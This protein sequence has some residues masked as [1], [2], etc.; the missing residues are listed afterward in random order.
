MKRVATPWAT[1]ALL[2]AI[3]AAAFAATLAPDSVAGWGFLR[4][5]PWSLTLLSHTLVHLNLVHLLGNLVV[6]AAVGPYVE[7]TLGPVRLL[8]VFLGGAVVGALA[9]AGLAPA[10]TGA[11]VGASGAVAAVLGYAAIRFL[12]ARV[13]LA[14]G[15]TVPVGAVAVLWLGLQAIGTVVRLGEPNPTGGTAFWTHL[16]G[17]VAGIG[18]A[19]LFRAP[20]QASL[21]QGQSSIDAMRGRGPAAVVAAAQEHLARHP[22][23]VAGW[24]Q[25]AVAAAD[26]HDPDVE[27]EAWRQILDR[28]PLTDGPRAVARLA[29]LHRLTTVPS[30]HRLRWADRFAQNAGS[31]ELAEAAHLLRWSVVN[32]QPED[33]ARPD[34][35]LAVADGCSDPEERDRLVR[36]LADQY[37]LHPATSLARN[38]GWLS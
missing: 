37:P 26:L 29:G 27:A 4:E 17:F 9:H 19:A 15:W 38:R 36:E 11:L 1:L 8:L 14:P 5:R 7:Q 25:L 30:Q 33:P 13:P 31:P 18:A 3:L 22:E 35:L 24:R 20:H 10:S 34:A 28:N 12:H 2:V 16:G 6:L 23:D 21:H 32:Q